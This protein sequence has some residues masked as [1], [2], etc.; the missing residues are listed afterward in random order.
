MMH[1]EMP[2]QANREEAA[3]KP[4][5]GPVIPEDSAIPKN[6]TESSKQEEPERQDAVA[7]PQ[8]TFGEAGALADSNGK[9]EPAAP[10]P[11]GSI[12]QRPSANSAPQTTSS[13]ARPTPAPLASETSAA[14]PTGAEINR[15][16]PLA[17]P[18]VE[19]LPAERFA[20]ERRL[21]S[22]STSHLPRV[23]STTTRPPAS[24]PLPDQPSRLPDR[25][26]VAAGPEK[27]RGLLDLAPS[28][29]LLR[30]VDS[31]DDGRFVL[32][33]LRLIYQG[34]SSEG[35]LFAA[36]AV[37]DITSIEF[38]RR[39]RDSR[40][41][42]WG[43]IGMVAAI[44]VWQVTTNENVGAVAGAVVAGISA[45]LLADYWFRPPGLVLR[46]GTPGGAVVGAVSGKRVREA[47]ELA[48][49]VQQLR[50]LAGGINSLGSSA[51]SGRPPGGSPG[52]Q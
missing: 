46:F 19:P 10:L 15:P 36:A 27:P 45:L 4:L 50:R 31:G 13:A 1:S 23:E 52:L 51:G 25:P 24:P 2:E 29:N 42:W 22:L 32:T 18:A 48:A 43:I 44:A 49:E 7:L 38:G 39:A 6:A 33:N 11:Y 40:S 16:K 30:E 9:A 21:S 5:V 3:N 26:A 17:S 35:A 12:F 34:R 37:A 20:A 41:A 14:L 8:P 28:E 47:E